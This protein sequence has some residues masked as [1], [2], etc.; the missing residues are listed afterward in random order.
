MRLHYFRVIPLAFFASLLLAPALEA[1][2]LTIYAGGL[3]PG[4]V[5]VDNVRT[6]LDRGPMFG[7][8][9][10]T[11][12]A[13]FLKLEGN[14]AFSND[15]LFPHEQPGV[16][17]AKGIMVNAN[18]LADLPAGKVVP[19]ATVGLGVMHQ[20]G[21]SDLPIGTKFAINYGGG[22]KLPKM[23]GPLG[24]R[25]DAR[26]YTATGVFSHAVNMFEFSGGVMF[27]F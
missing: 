27:S 7:I 19:Y 15:F 20:Y 9:L 17:N 18:L 16:T 22:L 3:F 21:S 11:G 24:F 8:R 12:F 5:T 6:S 1:Q 14:L 4:H 13:A 26:G 25:I 2:D 10:S 23:Y